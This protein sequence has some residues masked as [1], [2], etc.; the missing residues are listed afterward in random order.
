MKGILAQAANEVVKEIPRSG[1]DPDGRGRDRASGYARGYDSNYERGGGI[2][3]KGNLRHDSC[4][5]D[6][7]L[8]LEDGLASRHRL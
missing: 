5:G 1:R 4:E 6:A 8:P 7:S 2:V 3:T